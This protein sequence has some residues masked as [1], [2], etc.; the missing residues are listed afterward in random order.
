MPA[1]MTLSGVPPDVRQKSEFSTDDPASI[2]SIERPLVADIAQ[3][4][5]ARSCET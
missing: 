4:L 5:D 3:A 1:S 2:G